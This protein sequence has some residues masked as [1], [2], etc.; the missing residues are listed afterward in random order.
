MAGAKRRSPFTER[1]V[2][3]IRAIPRGKVATYGQI[4]VLAG[5]PSAARQVVRLLHSLSRSEGLPWHRVINS[6]GTI[7][8][9]G[10]G[11][12]LQRKLLEAEGVQLGLGGRI[13]FR[14]YLWRP[15]GKGLG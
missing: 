9:T 11:Y 12:E 14:S 8:L 7:S 15:R 13:D 4:A 10:E 3:I 6:K 1:V 5:F 2:R